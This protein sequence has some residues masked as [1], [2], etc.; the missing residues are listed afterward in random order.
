MLGFAA[1]ALVIVLAGAAIGATSIGGVLVVPA[2]TSIT[3]IAMPRAIAASSFGF[4][5]TG[6]W[7]WRS[8]WWGPGGASA[9][10]SPSITFKQQLGLNG[11]AFAGAIVGVVLLQFFP[12][13]WAR[14]WIAALALGSGVYAF[15]TAGR[16]GSAVR[17]L[18]GVPML[19]AFG[20]VVGV[21][22]SLSGTGGPVMLLPILLLI[23]IP[24]TPAIAT[25]LAVQLPIAVASSATHLLAGTLDVALGAVV[26]VALITGAWIGHRLAAH[27]DPTTLRRAVALVLIFSGGWFALT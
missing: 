27:A 9:R 26:G 22:S 21:G 12:A 11:A 18:P 20:L 15:A 8:A 2:L 7:A 19:I 17:G 3:D 4:L 6:L 16:G 10:A 13:S 23:G 14:L 1:A 24:V 5:L 25:A